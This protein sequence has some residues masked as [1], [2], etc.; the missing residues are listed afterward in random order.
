MSAVLAMSGCIA[1]QVFTWVITCA[2]S[3]SQVSVTCTSYP[4]HSSPRLV[5]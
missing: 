5:L 3:S 2:A 1:A 4:D